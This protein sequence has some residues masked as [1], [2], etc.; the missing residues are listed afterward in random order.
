MV[1]VER[2]ITCTYDEKCDGNDHPTQG[3]V[4]AQTSVA[5]A[6]EPGIHAYREGHYVDAE[7]DALHE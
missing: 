1:E 6:T 5:R 4:R 7:R 2:D 3:T